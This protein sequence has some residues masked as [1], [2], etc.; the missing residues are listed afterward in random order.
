MPIEEQIDRL[1][2]LP[3]ELLVIIFSFLPIRAAARTSVLSRRFRHLVPSLELIRTPAARFVTMAE[4]TL[5][6][7][8]L[9]QPLACLRLELDRHL[10]FFSSA[11]E[12]SFL[13]SLFIKAR[14]LGLRQLTI[15]GC[16]FS[17]SCRTLPLIFSI[18]SLEFLSLPRV[19]C[20]GDD[21]LF[22]SAVTLTNLKSL[23]IEHYIGDP[24]RLNRLL[25]QLCSLEDFSFGLGNVPAFN[26]FNQTI[27]RLKIILSRSKKKNSAVLSLPSLEL[28]H[29][30]Y[31]GIGL[32]HIGGDMP[33]LQKAV[34]N[35]SF[36]RKKDCSA[37]AGLLT[38]I[39][40]V[41]DLILHIK[42]S[43][44]ERYPFPILL[45]AGK[46]PPKFP[47]LKHLE[48][49]MCFHEHNFEAIVSLLHH[50][51]ALE[52]VKLVHEASISTARKRK[53]KRNR[54]DWRSV[55][56][57]NASGNCDYVHFT[58]LHLRQHREFTKLVG[59]QC[60]PKM[61]EPHC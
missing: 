36:L 7:R 47:N 61:V 45:E 16:G 4:Q 28:L 30:Q 13:P 46:D 3:D 18:T 5:L 25:S 15:E 19:I 26:L 58:D 23:S 38:F 17:P 27:R 54:D 42:E 24:H 11:S 39:S 51:P 60:S 34:L 32:P 20:E 43:D 9:S 57:Q 50:S 22:P 37:V 59:K 48:V 53:R 2:S 8:S 44:Y 6:R 52:S 33:S 1:S 14:S 56:P 41:E 49:T 55:L 29:V 12:S 35:L 31:D 40:H 21:S 10:T